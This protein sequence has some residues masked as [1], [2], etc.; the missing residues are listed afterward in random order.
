MRANL[1]VLFVSDLKGS[2]EVRFGVG[3]EGGF[4]GGSKQ[5]R[6]VQ[7]GVGVESSQITN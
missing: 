6:W 1:G 5:R 7:V 2:F 3:F 4:E